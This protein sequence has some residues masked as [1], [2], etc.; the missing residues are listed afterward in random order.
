[1]R[2][3]NLLDAHPTFFNLNGKP[4]VGRVSV[5]ENE[6]RS[7]ADTWLDP[8]G[9]KRAANPIK[10]NGAGK[11]ES[12]VFVEMPD[13]GQRIYTVVVEEFLGEQYSS[14]DEYWDDGEMWKGLY[15]FKLVVDAGSGVKSVTAGS[16][17]EIA[18]MDSGNGIVVATGFYRDGDCPARVFVYMDKAVF[19]EDGCTSIKSKD[20]GYWTWF[21]EPTVDSGCFGIIPSASS[22]D[23]SSGFLSLQTHLNSADIIKKVC[24]RSGRYLLSV[25]VDIN[26]DVKFKSNARLNPTENVS[27]SFR[28]VSAS[29]GFI[30][31]DLFDKDVSLSVKEGAFYF[32]WFDK[33]ADGAEIGN[34]GTPETIVVDKQLKL[35]QTAINSALVIGCGPKI[36]FTGTLAF[37]QC[38]FSGATVLGSSQDVSFVNCGKVRTSKVCD[39]FYAST[40][41]GST[42]GTKFIVD[43]EIVMDA[44]LSQEDTGFTTEDGAYFNGLAET[45]SLTID[46]KSI[47]MWMLSCETCVKNAKEIRL[48]WFKQNLST[49]NRLSLSC[50]SS[51]IFAVDLCGLSLSEGSS[52]YPM[53][54]RNGTLSGSYTKDLSLDGVN[55]TVSVSGAAL[56]V[57][58]SNVKFTQLNAKKLTISDSICS[59]TSLNAEGEVAI[60]GS[61]LQFTTTTING[62]TVQLLDS[63][64]LGTGSVST[65]RLEC[66]RTEMKSIDV[67]ATDFASVSLSK[68][69]SLSADVIHVN[70]SIIKDDD[71]IFDNT[72]ENIVCKDIKFLDGFMGRAEESY[73]LIDVNAQARLNAGIYNMA[74]EGRTELDVFGIIPSFPVFIT[75]DDCVSLLDTVGS[76][77]SY[78][79]TNSGP[80][81]T[82]YGI[83][84]KSR[85]KPG[86]VLVIMSCGSESRTKCLIGRAKRATGFDG[87]TDIVNKYGELQNTNLQPFPDSVAHKR[88]IINDGPIIL[89]CLGPGY[90]GSDSV[91]VFW[92]LNGDSLELE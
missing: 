76:S 57:K 32:S 89:Y 3:A 53:A 54:Y 9:T 43:S 70:S 64:V 81:G 58:D 52:Q 86:Q 78:A 66:D 65:T 83:I 40:I 80:S 21:P 37:S 85:P 45:G 41:A 56:T 91:P 11:T 13:S 62:T 14:M 36:K 72:T 55:G 16:V 22:T 61:S 19:P 8:E 31:R 75:Q 69:K 39:A 35:T 10:T 33:Y 29:P 12:Q 30:V 27:L 18:G 20:G 1:M 4:L 44:D 42:V 17:S 90:V 73:P 24:F 46:A 38:R 50:V 47:G 26:C 59:G 88:L 68:V 87:T 2:T 34:I 48:D 77:R 84:G 60:S 6:T 92:N 25:S 74:S 67:A 79:T 28:S 5:F 49:A 51:S 71:V 82:A 7:F 63:S 23:T 15:D